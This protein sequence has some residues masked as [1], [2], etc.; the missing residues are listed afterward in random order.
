[1]K[2]YVTPMILVTLTST[3]ILSLLSPGPLL[4]MPIPE[5]QLL[6]E[7]QALSAQMPNRSSVQAPHGNSDTAMSAPQ[8]SQKQW[9]RRGGRGHHM[10]G[11]GGCPMYGDGVYGASQLETINGRVVRIDRAGGQGLWLQVQLGVN[12]ETI[13]D[14]LAPS[15]PETTS[16]PDVSP[17]PAQT[18]EAA[19]IKVHL[20]PAWYLESQD[21]AI[22]LNEPIT[23][24]GIRSTW[25]QETTLIAAQIEY[26]G[27]TIEL[28][29]DNGYPMWRSW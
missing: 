17:S 15:D 8:L 19:T 13:S 3:G 24:T 28:R 5:A 27:D 25:H 9:G 14:S 10:Y 4:A 12:P 1:M 2:R 29:D 16:D 6:S 21:V 11:S 22:A 23:V 18:L 26:A 20:G 7:Q